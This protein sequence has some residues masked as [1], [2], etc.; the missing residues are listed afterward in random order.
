MLNQRCRQFRHPVRLLV[1][2]KDG[3]TTHRLEAAAEAKQA[4]AWSG[5][6]CEMSLIPGLDG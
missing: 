5:L 4:S 3:R 1:M 6:P 2:A